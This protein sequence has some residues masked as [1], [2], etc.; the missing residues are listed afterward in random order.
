MVGGFKE[1]PTLFESIFGFSLLGVGF[2]IPNLNR[3][4]VKDKVQSKNTGHV[5]E[6]LLEF[7]LNSY[8]PFS[9]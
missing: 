6:T 4:L 3:V 1:V 8:A 7:N 2:P 5:G 9:T